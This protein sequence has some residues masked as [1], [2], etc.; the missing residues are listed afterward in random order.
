MTTPASLQFEG[1]ET[2][3]RFEHAAMATTFVLYLG[4]D[5]NEAATL[6]AAA[7][8]AFRLIERLED[9]LS[10]YREGSDVSRINRAAEGETLRISEAT[11]NCLCTALE[12]SAASQGAF[13]PFAGA[14]SLA[15]KRQ[16]VPPHLHEHVA[17]DPPGTPCLAVEI[18][19]GLVTKLAGRRWLDL[20]AVGKGYALDAAADSLR[21]WGIASAFLVA[22]GSSVLAF[23]RGPGAGGAWPVTVLTGDGRR[24]LQLPTPFALGASGEG[25]QPGHLVRPRAAAA[26]K[27][28]ESPRRAYVLA[29][30]AALADA[31]STALW[32]TPTAD[33]H[34]VA[35]P[36]PEV[37]FL[38]EDTEPSQP[39]E[40]SGVFSAT[41][42]IAPR[43]FLVVPCWG[44]SRRLPRF[45]PLLCQAVSQHDSAAIEI[46]V[47]D[48]G[49]TADEVDA[50][51]TIVE[52]LRT[53]YPFLRPLVGL[54][55]HRGKG[56]A[57][58]RGWREAPA[59]CGWLAFVD[60]DGSVPPA[61]VLRAI[62]TALARET[63]QL[64][65]ATNRRHSDPA[66]PVQRV[67]RRAWVGAAF[68][69]WSRRRLKHEAIDPQCGCKVVPAAWVRRHEW[70]EQ[71]YGLD[72]ELLTAARR[73]NL[74][75]EN[76][77]IA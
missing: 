12:V 73:E 6:A 34:D 58:V 1:L 7:Q 8:E 69:W 39:A 9:Q 25:F 76:L 60:A 75:V 21:D 47:V 40:A 67:R 24:T 3:T 32:L 42:P 29:P 72:L 10:F 20:G 37:S 68:A 44:E 63:P 33:R 26:A 71:G 54:G 61:D 43:C 31:L 11:L 49:S 30:T 41:D 56:A 13:D 64:V 46:Q 19:T 57:I 36:W 50:T 74:V 52:Q 38:V 2:W 53:R 14:S 59:G 22:G 51:T 16:P 70:R 23:G 48:D 17:D 65:I 18:E 4:Q 28:A 35:A 45:L 66:Y 62:E 5:G 55:T 27:V 15:A 77:A